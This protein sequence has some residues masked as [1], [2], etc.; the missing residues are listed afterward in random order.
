MKYLSHFLSFMTTWIVS[1][2][3]FPS[4]FRMDFNTP[5]NYP[6]PTIVGWSFYAG[7]FPCQFL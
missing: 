2:S 3:A 7:T 5:M 1:P 4:C 6:Q